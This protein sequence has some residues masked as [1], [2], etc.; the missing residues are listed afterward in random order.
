MESEN[1]QSTDLYTLLAWFEKNRKQIISAIVIVIVVGIVIAFVQWNR[2]QKEIAAGEALSAVVMTGNSSKPSADSLLKV[3]ADNAGTVAAGR[4]LL[5]AAGQ[6]FTDG[7]VDGAQKNFQKF[8]TDYA[9]SPLTPQA[10][11]GVAACLEAQGKKAEAIAA[12]K[13]VADRFGEAN[14]RTHAKFSLARLNE[15]EGK[16]ELARD[17][18]IELMQEAQRE[19][20]RNSQSTFGPEAFGRLSDLMQKH[21]EL[22][23][24]SAPPTTTQV[25]PA[26]NP[27]AAGSK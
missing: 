12:F 5:M 7:N 20:Q 13:E 18:Y 14:T 15:T 3:A 24:Q 26:A 17:Q 25:V 1:T 27:G 11:L 16:L 8:L 6:M 10:K 19:S 2:E 23:K 9:G 4:A 21:P 22:A